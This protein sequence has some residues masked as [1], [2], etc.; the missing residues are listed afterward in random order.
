[1]FQVPGSISENE[2]PIEMGP[3]STRWPHW[4][5][6]LVVP[7]A[8]SQPLAPISRHSLAALFARVVARRRIRHRRGSGTALVVVFPS[9]VEI[10]FI[11]LL[12]L[13]PL[14]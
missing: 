4:L 8:V 5:Q 3:D 14:Q 12:R 13:N 6:Q 9:N 7:G 1:M 11:F 10:L 2:F